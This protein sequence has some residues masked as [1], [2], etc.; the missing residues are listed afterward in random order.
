MTP[1][2]IDAAA[3]Q[4]SWDRQQEGYLP[5]REERFAAMLEVVDA[6]AGGEPK[7]VLDLAG[8]TGSISLR[9]LRRF[10]DAATTLLDLDPLLLTIARASLPAQATIV[11]AD[12]RTP[13]WVSALPYRDYDAVLAATA[14][15]WLQPDRL[16][17]LYAEIR[18]VLRPGGVFVNADHMPDD[19][20][21]DLTLRLAARAEARQQARYAAGALLSW[22]RWWEHVAADPTL[23][24]LAAERKRLF[25]DHV[26]DWNPPVS[27]H[28]NA[29]RAGGYQEVGLVWR[30]TRDAAVAAVR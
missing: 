18:T 14:L 6:V 28:I 27:W 26:T 4:E 25:A 19:G 30:G 9:T 11:T 15:H 29:L 16:T 17:A 10:P 1:Y 22:R 23:G 12:L 21:P 5:D 20:L 8:G 24:P 7:R 2:D 13:E 3:W